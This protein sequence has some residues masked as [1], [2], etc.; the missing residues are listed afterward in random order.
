MAQNSIDLLLLDLEL[1]P[2]ELR[3]IEEAYNKVNG[4]LKGTFGTEA[5]IVGNALFSHSQISNK[6][7]F[8]DLFYFNFFSQ[9]LL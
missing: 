4:I 2:H 8:L 3:K 1:F 6:Y 5:F 9:E 7:N